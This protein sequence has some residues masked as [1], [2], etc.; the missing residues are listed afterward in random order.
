MKRPGWILAAV[1]LP[2]FLGALDLTI[3]SAV[4]PA[5]IADLEVP[6]QTGLDEASWAVTGY[7]LAYAVS[8]TFMGRV[9]DLWGRRRVFL[10][11]LAVFF[12]GSWWVAASPGAPAD[13]VYRIVRALAGGRPDR[14]LM[15]LYAMISGRV[16][17]A[18]GAG[19]MVP[20]GMALVADLFPPERRALP[21][22]L[23]GAVDTAG[24]VLGHL[25]GGIMVQFFAWP[26]LFWINLPLIAVL[27][28]AIAWALRGLPAAPNRAPLDGFGVLWL[29]LALAGWTIGLGAG[30]A[31][32]AASS[33]GGGISPLPILLGFLAF[34]LFLVHELRTPQPLINLRL[35]RN[36]NVSASSSLNLMVGFCLMVGLV[37]VPLFINMIGARGLAEGALVSG[38]LL[39]AFTVPLA[40]AA[41]PG[42]WLTGKLGY[43]WTTL[44]GMAVA[45]CG[46]GL[47]TTWKPELAGQA[48]A[49]IASGTAPPGNGVWWMIAGLA[50]AGIGLG[51]TIAPVGTAVINAAGE[52]ERGIAA[53]AVII[54][55]LIGMSLSVSLMTTYGLRRTTEISAGLLQGVPFTDFASIA[56]AGVQAVTRVTSEMAWIALVVAAAGLAP[57]ALLGNHDRYIK[58]SN[59]ESGK[60][61]GSTMQAGGNSA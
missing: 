29:S 23:I 15:A 41:L 56:E 3:V 6:L 14:S 11:C 24:W 34:G 16:V 52:S 49:W 9:S 27:F 8:M 26:V 10:L 2:V 37:S 18:F 33:S 31:A 12:L 39:S 13:L 50:T 21:L 38:L 60:A 61:S 32:G 45:V 59:P 7:L 51:L 5:V 57:A 43:R 47:M 54:L 46:F 17:Q 1:C 48:V 30:D 22:G 20:V 44:A 28:A 35:F 55:R 4:L 40:L 19:A 36:R 58:S 25:Y 53:A 42:G